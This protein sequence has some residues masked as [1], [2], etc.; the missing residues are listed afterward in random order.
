[1]QLQSYV[2]E[3]DVLAESNRPRWCDKLLQV[4]NSSKE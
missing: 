2:Y 3:L 4:Y 1:M